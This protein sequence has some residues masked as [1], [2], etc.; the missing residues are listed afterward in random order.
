MSELRVVLFILLPF[1]MGVIVG[2]SIKIL[3][4]VSDLDT[5]EWIVYGLAAFFITL[6]CLIAFIVVMVIVGVVK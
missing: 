4:W 5:P 3:D 6:D 1:I 2:G